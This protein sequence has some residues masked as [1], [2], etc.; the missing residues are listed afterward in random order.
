MGFSRQEYRS[1]LP[2]PPLDDLPDPG[3]RPRSSAL[4]ILYHL[5]HHYCWCSWENGLESKRSDLEKPIIS[6]G[7]NSEP[8]LPLR[9]RAEGQIGPELKMSSKC[10]PNWAGKYAGHVKVGPSAQNKTKF[11]K[12]TDRNKKYHAW[13]QPSKWKQVSCSKAENQMEGPL[14]HGRVINETTDVLSPSGKHK[15]QYWDSKEVTG[16]V[17]VPYSWTVRL[18]LKMLI[19][20]IWSFNSPSQIHNRIVTPPWNWMS[21]IFI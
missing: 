4:Q 21:Q 7:K 10:I 12:E 2:F 9:A 11:R 15:Q 3:I 17:G 20:P 14:H 6:R 13:K 16:M 18:S 19:L 1:G 5:S 8:W